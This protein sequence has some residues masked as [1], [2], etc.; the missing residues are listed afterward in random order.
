VEQRLGG[1][2][3]WRV[4][5]TTNRILQ[6]FSR[7]NANC[8]IIGFGDPEVCCDLSGSNTSC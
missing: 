6:A 1:A 5:Y 2:P 3:T 7:Y 8:D 4:T